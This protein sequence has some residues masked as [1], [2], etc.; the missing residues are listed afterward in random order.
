[1]MRRKAFNLPE[2]LAQW[3]NNYAFRCRGKLTQSQIATKALEA[4]REKNPTPED[5]D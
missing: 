3:I 4:F 2:D 5:C 1:M